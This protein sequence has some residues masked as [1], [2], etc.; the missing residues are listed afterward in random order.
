VSLL[1][2]SA[3]GFCFY[4]IRKPLTNISNSY[5]P[6]DKLRAVSEVEP[7]ARNSGVKVVFW[8]FIFYLLLGIVIT[9]SV[10]IGGV[11]VVFAYLIIPA[12]ISAIFSSHLVKQLIIIW[13]AVIVASIAGLLFAYYF[14]F[15]V[16]PA[17]A[18]F[19]GGELTVAAIIS[20]LG[21]NY[22]Q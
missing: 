4:L 13:V 11:V 5:Q 2:F 17:V 19:L 3:V 7:Q 8:D 18:L 16:G 21:F 14:D 12:T 22:R 6:F 20:K 1:T 9:L 15:S 10:Q